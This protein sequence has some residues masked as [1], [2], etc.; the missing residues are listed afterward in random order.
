MRVRGFDHIVLTVGSIDRTCDFYEKVLGMTREIFAGGRM[1]LTFGAQKINLHQAGNEFEPKAA[2]PKPGSADF[3]LIV[4]DIDEAKATL[5]MA[6]VEVVEGPVEKIGARGT[7]LSI[8]CR[9]PDGNL[10]E[11]AEYK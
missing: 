3:C 8:Y 11:L 7:L 10:V 2:A 5:E 1:A 4:A 6:G 9:D